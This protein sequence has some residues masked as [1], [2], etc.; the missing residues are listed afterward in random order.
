VVPSLRVTWPLELLGR[1]VVGVGGEGAEHGVAKVD[2]DDLGPGDGQLRVHV[3]HHVV[4]Q[5][6]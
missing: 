6:G 2:Q 4:D 3:R 1:V 5:L